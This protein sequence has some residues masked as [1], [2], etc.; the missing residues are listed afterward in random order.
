MAVLTFAR[1]FSRPYLHNRDGPT[2]FSFQQKL[3]MEEGGSYQRRKSDAKKGGDSPALQPSTVDDIVDSDSENFHSHPGTPTR[4]SRNSFSYQDDWETFPPLDQLSVFDL[5]DNFSLSRR[6]E[7]LQQSINS[8]RDK[9]KRQQERLKST[10]KHARERVVGEW[11][12]RVPTA[13]EQLEKYRHRMKL[14]VERLGTRW[15]AASAVTLREKISFIAGV[16]NIFISGYLLGACPEYFY[17]WFS[18]QLAYFMPI[19]FYRYH[20]IGYQ[21]FLAD[22]CYFV[23]M[24]CM[25]CIWV[26]P[27]S[28]RLFIST[29]CLVFGNNAVAIAM[30]RNSMVFHSMDKV[31]SL[32]IHIMPPVTFHCLVHLTPMETMKERFPAIY[33]IKTSESGSPDHFSLL[34]MML[35][36]TVPYMIWQLSYHCFITVRRADKIAAGRPTSFTWLRR[37]Y[38]KTW[39]GRFVLSLPESLQAPA[40]MMIQYIYALLTII[41]CPLWLWSRWASGLFLTGLFILSIHNGATYYID[42]F[43]KRFQKELE[44]LKKDVARWQSSPE[45]AM[46][47]TIPGLGTTP[48]NVGER[49]SGSSTASAAGSPDKT[50]IENIPLLDATGVATAVEGDS[51]D[52]PA[53]RNRS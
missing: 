30:W 3:V 13:E 33:Q 27:H 31:V 11:K 17:I 6:L 9:V 53:L 4:S 25:L 40:F 15:N 10:S 28:R 44:E 2:I 26:F 21:Y 46:S 8:Q 36:A 1:F 20:K 47:P 14:G 32:F 24:L 37:S 52:R 49:E 38:A 41:P 50:G 48:A 18:G 39:I 35:W 12:R 19:R 5:F 7:K 22:L 45:G 51:S 16:L 43:G 42:V 23:N 34:S 29:F